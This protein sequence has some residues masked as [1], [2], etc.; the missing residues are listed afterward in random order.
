MFNRPESASLLCKYVF[1]RPELI[2][3][4]GDPMELNFEDLEIPKWNI[5]AVRAQRIGEKSRSFV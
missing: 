3:K 2:T 4:V 5:P 1:N